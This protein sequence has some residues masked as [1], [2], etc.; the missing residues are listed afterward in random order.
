MSD[1]ITKA[2]D[3]TIAEAGRVMQDEIGAGVDLILDRLL[4]YCAAQMVVSTNKAEAAQA[5][6]QCA[7]MVQS[8]AF[9]HLRTGD[10]GR[11]H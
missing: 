4:T 6:R 3:A 8:G 10:A 5:F 2:C 11:R 9:D 1:F 7:K